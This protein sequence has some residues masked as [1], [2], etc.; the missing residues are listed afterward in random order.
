MAW[1]EWNRETI[2]VEGIVP[3]ASSV[4][5][6][7]HPFRLPSR[8]H[9]QR[10]RHHHHQHPTDTSYEYRDFDEDRSKRGHYAFVALWMMRT[11]RR[12]ERIGARQKNQVVELISKVSLP[13]WVLAAHF[14]AHF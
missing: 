5:A 9:F 8:R 10:R 2:F 7:H 1:W 13:E 14:S 6:H 11:T 12:K 3:P 4:I